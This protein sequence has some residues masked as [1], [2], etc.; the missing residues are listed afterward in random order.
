MQ[1][2]ENEMVAAMTCSALFHRCFSMKKQLK[3]PCNEN[4]TV[5]NNRANLFAWNC[6][7]PAFK[8]GIVTTGKK[9]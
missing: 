5:R 8:T 2:A 6:F 7:V 9:M 3:D 4:S 1:R